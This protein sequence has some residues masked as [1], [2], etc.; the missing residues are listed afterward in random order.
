[1]SKRKLN[2]TARFQIAMLEALSSTCS[3][4]MLQG[5]SDSAFTPVEINELISLTGSSHDE[6]EIQ[7]FLYVLEGQKLVCPVPEGDLTSRHW[8]L[9]SE[10]LDTLKRARTFMNAA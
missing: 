9:T 2:D 6:K 7:R 1:M 5:R 3:K 10:G 8:R 4:H